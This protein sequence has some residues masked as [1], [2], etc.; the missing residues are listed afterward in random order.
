MIPSE[1]VGTATT[2][3]AISDSP[4]IVASTA[5]LTCSLTVLAPTARADADRASVAPLALIALPLTNQEMIAV[6]SYATTPSSWIVCVAKYVT[7][8]FR[9]GALVV[10]MRT[11]GMTP[12]TIVSVIDTLTDVYAKTIE[13]IPAALLE[14]IVRSVVVKFDIDGQ[15]AVDSAVQVQLYVGFWGYESSTMALTVTALVLD[16]RAD[17]P[18]FS[19]TTGVGATAVNVHDCD[20]VA[21]A[22]SPV[23]YTVSV[24]ATPGERAS[25][26]M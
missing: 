20:A 22:T 14:E 2:T 9:S 26:G 16:T 7:G 3:I 12:D 19:E 10:R 18:R 11:E 6:P 24:Y 21:A 4:K 5:E 13:K 25:G 23:A 1:M 8:E 15:L 17:A